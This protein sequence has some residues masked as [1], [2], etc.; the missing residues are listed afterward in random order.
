MKLSNVIYNSHTGVVR[1]GFY[2]TLLLVVICVDESVVTV[3]I[4]ITR[5]NNGLSQVSYFGCWSQ[6][7]TS[8]FY[9]H[10]RTFPVEL[11]FGLEDRYGF[12]PVIFFCFRII[13]A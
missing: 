4:W 1:L 11:M 13:F 12:K 7:G 3:E 2:C 9:D 8:L 5:T 10:R 6:H